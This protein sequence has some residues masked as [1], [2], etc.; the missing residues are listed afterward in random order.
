MIAR[1]ALA[2]ATAV[3]LLGCFVGPT[4]SWSDTG[5]TPDTKEAIAHRLRRP[6]RTLVLGKV[7]RGDTRSPDG[8]A[9]SNCKESGRAG[10]MLD[11]LYGFE[12]HET[13]SYRFELAPA[14]DGVFQV[15]EFEP[16]GSYYRGIEC[17]A[18]RKGSKAALSLALGPGLYWVVVDG[19]RMD[20]AGPYA[21]RVDLDTSDKA[22]IRP[23]QAEKVAPLCEAASILRIG[24]RVMGGFTST[25]G[26]ARASCGALGGNVVH[27]FTVPTPMRLKLVAAA[28]FRPAVEIR[29]ACQGAAVAC[30]K[31]PKGENEI[32]IVQD[33][34]VGD[35]FVVLDGTEV[36]PRPPYSSGH[37]GPG[38]EGAY[39]ID[40]EEVAR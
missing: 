17:A 9:S 23:E 31:A 12:V 34:E 29:K 37:T 18:A 27:R 39:V 14:F 8:R 38:V 11:H 33:L 21:L 22:E 13:A 2:F 35:Y 6:E 15:Q 3:G 16:K 4:T 20:E 10:Q 32:E 36:P 24:D 30:A 25:P 5:S 28:H 7:A 19:Y 40:L 26:G 1:A